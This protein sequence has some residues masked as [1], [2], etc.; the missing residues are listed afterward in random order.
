MVEAKNFSFDN[1]SYQVSSGFS[2][3]NRGLR[4]V[5]KSL[6]GSFNAGEL[7]AIIGLSG[8]GKTSMLKVLSGFERKNV[9]G[10]IR[11]NGCEVSMNLVRKVSSYIMHDFVLHNCLTVHE[12]MMFAASFKNTKALE[13]LQKIESILSSLSLL[14]QNGTI[15]QCLSGGEQKRL[16]IAIELFNDPL[17][18]L[19]DEPATGLDFSSAHQC[20]QLLR[21]LAHDEG[22]I[23]ISTIHPS[24]ARTSQL[25][26]HIYAIADGCCI[27]QGAYENLVP[28]LAEINLICPED[29]NPTDFLFE[30]ATN[31][32]GDQNRLLTE[33]ICNG[34]NQEYRKLRFA[35][36]NPRKSFQLQSQSN[37]LT[38]NQQVRH[39]MH[40]SYLTLVRNKVH[41]PLRIIA[42]I[43]IGISLGLVYKDVGNKASR[44]IDNYR[45]L[46]S[47]TMMQAILAYFSLLLSSKYFI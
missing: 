47:M 33:K 40:R 32:Y 7:S 12:T 18:L 24:S 35:D 2:C 21:N 37:D 5:L 27:Y 36:D 39:L 19:L 20:I 14:D 1:V 17:I 25:F 6:N 38:F 11:I 4:P 44:F 16:S 43:L 15:V 3:E 23:I 8:S 10:T 26:D 22:K 29:Y 42:H 34:D 46:Q 9:L 41:L 45:Y 28:F 31:A 30:I 13:K